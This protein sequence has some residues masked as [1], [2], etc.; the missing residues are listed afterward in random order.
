MIYLLL[1]FVLVTV[2]ILALAGMILLGLF[3]W[4]EL[5]DYARAR[6]AMRHVAERR[7]LES[8]HVA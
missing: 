6:Y 2:P 7:P 5:Q 3:I 8:L 4:S 1:V